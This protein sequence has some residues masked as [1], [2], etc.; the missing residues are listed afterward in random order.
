MKK[1]LVLILVVALCV[2]ALFSCKKT[3]ASPLDDVAVMYSQSAPTK[4]SAT[5][6]HKIGYYE[7]NCSYEIV[8]GYVDGLPAS[9]YT[10]VVEEVRTVEEGAATEDILE[11]IKKTTK[12]TEAIEGQGARV[13]SI[14]DKENPVV[15]KW[16]PNGTVWTIGRGTM[17]LNLDKNAVTNVVYENNT[18]T[19]T[20]PESN[21]ATV[22]DEYGQWSYSE[23]VVGDVEVTII[24]DGPVITS[25][26]LHYFLKGDGKNLEDSEMTVTVNY[27][28]KIE[29]I[30]IR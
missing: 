25:I 13:T 5:T 7:L 10:S 17:G 11:L 20:I 4:V 18:L 1:I 9:V 15:G 22:L 27:D 21:V 3:E 19:F 28:Y 30:T 2:P 26:Q 16:N 24:D 23:D 8:T 12:I 29:Q 14:V 6:V